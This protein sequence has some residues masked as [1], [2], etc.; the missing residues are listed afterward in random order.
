MI[1]IMIM[2]MKLTT[3]LRTSNLMISLLVILLNF[4]AFAGGNS[5]LL[6]SV[7]ISETNE[8]ITGTVISSKDG[9]LLIG[10]TALPLPLAHFNRGRV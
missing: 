4:P 10:V 6:E 7:T 8:K 5:S 3:S 1:M 2:I 9:Q